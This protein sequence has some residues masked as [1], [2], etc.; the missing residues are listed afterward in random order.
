MFQALL[1]NALPRQPGLLRWQAC[2]AMSRNCYHT[3]T[4]TMLLIQPAIPPGFLFYNQP[5][6]HVSSPTTSYSIPPNF[7]ICNSL[8][9]HV[10][11]STTSFFAKFP[12]MQ[13]ATLPCFLLYNQLLHPISLYNKLLYYVPSS[14]TSYSAMFPLLSLASLPYFLLFYELLYHVPLL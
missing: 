5:L 14:V 7:L 3:I 1:C 2:Q 10:S 8:L 13:P 6:Y 12:H 11:S 4:V 9:Y